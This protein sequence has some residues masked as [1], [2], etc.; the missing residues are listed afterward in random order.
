MLLSKMRW[1]YEHPSEEKV[2]SLSENLNISALTASL[3]VQRGLEE[4]EEARSFLFDQKA[5]FHDPF[6]LKGMKEAVERINKAIEEQES[7][8]IFGD[9]DA[10][11]VTSTSVLLHTLKER[12]AKVDFYIPDR[13]KEGYGPNEQAFRYIKEQ[14]ASLVITVDTGIASV[15]EARIAKEIGLDLIITDHHE[16]SEELP[17]ALAIVH[18]KQPGCEYPFKELAGVGVAFKVAHALLGKLPV[19]LLDLA[20]IG[21]I[22]DLVP[23]YDENRWIAKKGLMQLRQSRRPGL[24][25]LLK[26]AG[27]TLE[28]ANEETVGFQIAPR[29]NAVGRIEQADPA[30]HLLMTEDMDEAEELARFVQ[31]L[32]KERQKIVSTI[33][34]EAIQMVEETGADQSAIVVAKA[35]WNPGVVGIVAS[36]LTDTFSRPAIVLGI[37]EETQMAKGSARSIPGF[38]LFFHL[39]K[40]RDI[41]PHFGGHPMAAG[42][43]LRADD[44]PLLR[45]RLNQYA[46]ETLT[47]E[48]FIPIQR[49]DAVCKVD[50]MTVQAIEEVGLLSP[51][52]MQNPKPFIMIEDAQLEDIRT[53]GANQN[54]IKM[55]LKD[56]DKL[57]DCVGFHQGKLKEEL[58]PGSQIS[59]VGEVSINEWN[60]RKKP[61]LMLKDARVDE[62][63]LFDLRGK[64]DWEKKVSTLDPAKTMVFCFDEETKKQSELVDIPIHLIDAENVSTFD[65]Q[66]KYV[67]FADVPADEHLL[68]LLLE[69]QQPARIYTVFQRKE[70]HFMSSFPSR[71]QFK[72]FYG[73]LFKRGSFPIKEQ[74]MELAKHR[75]WTKDTII[76]MTKVFFELGF[77]KIE[78]GVLS[79]VRDAPKKD[80]TASSSYTAK[81]RLMELDQTLTYS[82]AKELKEWL[83]S[84]MSEVSPVL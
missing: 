47:E 50:E 17:E 22:A 5:E 4:V 3:L 45:E 16:P 10:D 42:M 74:G 34:E 81:Q 25:A 37:D 7:I 69:N 62:W 70:D 40:C 23:L 66:E 9:Y 26:E 28:E 27:A 2:K 24:K 38:D 77:V 78:N 59:V 21:T 51:F 61:Q 83:N 1:E 80:L 14:G 84:M 32:N 68:K 19:E 54:H 49:V 36:K 71:D 35:G 79:I 8:V 58:V 18:P 52:G 13:F 65:V 15:N 43:T 67:I 64:K 31:E 33:T 73:F 53:I 60:N 46:N 11:G 41:L 57:L 39:S 55:S 76:F 30:V 29:L 56:E 63:Q 12:S 75:G 82:S 72:W 20:A 44:V 6:L 48:D